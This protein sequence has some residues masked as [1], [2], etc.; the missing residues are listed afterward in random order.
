MK[1]LTSILDLIAKLETVNVTTH[2]EIVARKVFQIQCLM[3][4]LPVC[5]FNIWDKFL[6]LI[7]VETTQNGRNS[8]L[9]HLSSTIRQSSFY[10]KNA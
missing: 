7:S 10:P 8:T 2:V 4:N 5:S 6:E 1:I 3:Y 9:Q